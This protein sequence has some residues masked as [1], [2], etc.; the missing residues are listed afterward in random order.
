MICASAQVLLQGLELF[1]FFTWGKRVWR[2]SRAPPCLSYLYSKLNIVPLTFLSDYMKGLSMLLYQIQ[3]QAY[4]SWN[5]GRGVRFNQ[6]SC[7][8]FLTLLSSSMDKAYRPFTLLLTTNLSLFLL[9]CNVV[10]RRWLLNGLGTGT[11]FLH[12]LRDGSW[13]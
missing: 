2:F 9:R 6:S 11:W 7:W 13:S 5:M 8:P 4:I 12:T 10:C 3:R 1:P